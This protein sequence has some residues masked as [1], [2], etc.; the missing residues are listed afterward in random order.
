[1]ELLQ[2]IETETAPDIE[3]A[4]QI[5]AGSIAQGGLVFLFGN[6]HSR[7]MCE[8]MTPRQG[9]YPGW[10][11]LVELALSNHANIVGANGLR[12]PLKLEKVEGYAEEILKGF[13][14]GR[15]D[16]FIIIS[17][18]GIRPVLVEMALVA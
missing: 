8:E 7:M 13:R 10:V 1:M 6:G 16:A 14:F 5:C 15:H 18:S 3:K 4:A 17:T 11:A 2:R 12:A 9:C